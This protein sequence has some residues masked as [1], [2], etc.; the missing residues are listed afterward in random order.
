MTPAKPAAPAPVVAPE[1]PARTLAAEL[2]RM[3][4]AVHGKRTPTPAPFTRRVELAP[5]PGDESLTSAPHVV[6]VD[7]LSGG[8]YL[9]RHVFG[10]GLSTFAG[11][12][13]ELAAWL[14]SIA[15]VYSEAEGA[16]AVGNLAAEVGRRKP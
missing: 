4:A 5:T 9:A 11:P 3:R 7:A 13:E 1:A 8:Q 16:E 15:S 10:G 2:G 14:R 12:A 6:E